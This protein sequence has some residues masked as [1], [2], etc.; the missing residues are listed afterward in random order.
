MRYFEEEKVEKKLGGAEKRF[1]WGEA[2]SSGLWLQA[3][4]KKEEQKAKRFGRETSS[5][6]LTEQLSA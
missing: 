1:E 4:R 3:V 6:L 5:A 2:Q